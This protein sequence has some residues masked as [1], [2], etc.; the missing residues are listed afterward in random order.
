MFQYAYPK[1]T[2]AGNN[3][4]PLDAPDGQLEYKAD[5]FGFGGAGGILVEP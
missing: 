1:T 3:V 4:L 2:A 5:S